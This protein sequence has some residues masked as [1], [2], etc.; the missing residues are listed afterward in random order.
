M[1]IL[2]SIN[3]FFPLNPIIEFGMGNL[4][5]FYNRPMCVTHQLRVYFILS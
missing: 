2:K 1:G 4:C 3:F 5:G